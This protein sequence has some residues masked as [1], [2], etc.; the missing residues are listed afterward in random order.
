MPWGFGRVD[1]PKEK[2]KTTPFKVHFWR[3]KDGAEVDFIIDLFKKQIP[4]EVKSEKLKKPQ[5]SRSFQSFIEKYRPKQ[6]LVV[7]L[8]LRT[9]R[10]LRKT[11]IDFLTF[12][13]LLGWKLKD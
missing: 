8:S 2:I 1:S 13:K 4:I 7:N 12:Y 3:I 6:A 5:I 9:T 11:Q 10:K